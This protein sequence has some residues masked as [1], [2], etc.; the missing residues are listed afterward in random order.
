[1]R[2]RDFVTL[3]GGAAAAW[4]FV[5][6]AQQ[7]DRNRY[8][9]ALQKAK[10]AYEKI[11]HPGEAARSNYITLLI[12]MREKAARLNSDEW[13]AIDTEIKQHPAPKDSDSK[14]LSSLRV[15]KWGSPRHEYLYRNDGTWTMLPAEEDSTRGSWRI[16]GNQYFDTAVIRPTETSQY[17]IILLTRNN[18]VFSDETDVF[19]ETRLK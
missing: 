7:L 5:A 16:E 4:P 15:G 19:Y 6:L 10:R 18:F 3:L 13:Q 14:R 12:Q 8:I 11:S 1:M 9:G 2:R 17:T